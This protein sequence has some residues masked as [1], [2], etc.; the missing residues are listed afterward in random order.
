MVRIDTSQWFAMVAPLREAIAEIRADAIVQ[1]APPEIAAKCEASIAMTEEWIW[2]VTAATGDPGEMSE[3]TAK[4]ADICE[5]VA[6][7]QEWYAEEK[8]ARML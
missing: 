1:D 4:F 3:A 8:A 7:L 5:I 6:E 2:E